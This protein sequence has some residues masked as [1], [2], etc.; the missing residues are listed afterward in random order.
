MLTLDGAVE[1]ARRPHPALVLV[2]SYVEFCLGSALIILGL[3]TLLAA[4]LVRKAR[5]SVP[6]EG[7][8]YGTS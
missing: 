4:E 7:I 5:V 3:I 8:W 2:E 6:S 1:M